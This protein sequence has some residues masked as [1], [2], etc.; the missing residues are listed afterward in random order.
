M[1]L[2]F[3]A[4]VCAP[5]SGTSDQPV[6]KVHSFANPSLMSRATF[7]CEWVGVQYCT[8]DFKNAW[9]NILKS[10]LPQVFNNE[11]FAKQFTLV[12]FWIKKMLPLPTP[13]NQPTNLCLLEDKY[14]KCQ[15]IFLQNYFKGKHTN[16]LLST[17]LF[18]PGLYREGITS[19]VAT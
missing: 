17:W 2:H 10:Y 1:A 3:K 19:L 6:A 7:L 5:W 4:I 9:T 14:C 11:I 18:Y 16:G 13:W 12:G 8:V 15:K